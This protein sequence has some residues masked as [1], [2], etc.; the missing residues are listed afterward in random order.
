MNL[1]LFSTGISSARQGFATALTEMLAAVVAFVPTSALLRVMDKHLGG[2]KP[3]ED[4]EVK[5]A[6]ERET[7][8]GRVFFYF[9]LLQA[10]LVLRE[11]SSVAGGHV[12]APS[13]TTS[14]DIDTM[15]SDIVGMAARKPYLRESCFE[16]LVA[17][18]EE[19]GNDVNVRMSFAYFADFHHVNP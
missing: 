18:V 14:A 19:V 4:V 1:F 11:T 15:V 5:P 9:A 7:L 17:C 2:A 10:G 8:F 16:W 3:N 13:P 12:D 6:D